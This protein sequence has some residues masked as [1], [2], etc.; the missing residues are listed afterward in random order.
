MTETKAK[1]R[2]SISFE[3]QR[4]LKSD[5]KRKKK[6]KKKKKKKNRSMEHAKQTQDF[7]HPLKKQLELP[8]CEIAQWKKKKKKKTNKTSFNELPDS[9]HLV[10]ST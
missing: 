7:P 5:E 8:I 4:C 6:K 3:V 9:D 1:R 10:V 2:R